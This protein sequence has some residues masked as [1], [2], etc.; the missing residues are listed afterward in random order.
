MF[1][2][3]STVDTNFSRH[4]AIDLGPPSV[5]A[6]L[7]L[8]AVTSVPEA[9]TLVLVGVALVGIGTLARRG[10]NRG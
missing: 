3:R 1:V 2:E 6:T 8:I 9:A 5:D 7:T 10:K 4:H